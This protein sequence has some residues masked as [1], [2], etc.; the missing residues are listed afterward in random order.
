MA[1][2]LSVLLALDLPGGLVKDVTEYD[3]GPKCIDTKNVRWRPTGKAEKLGGWQSEV[4][5]SFI[6]TPRAAKNWRT[7]EGHDC[8]VVCTQCRVE[9]VYD[10][11][12][13]DITP[14][15]TT[16]NPL[17]NNPIATVN[18]ES[19]V[20]VTWAGHGAIE[21]TRVI[22]SGAV[23]VNG[24]TL[25]GEFTITEIVNANSFKVDSGTTASGTG[26]GGGAAVVGQLL[27]NCGNTQA[28]PGLGWGAGPWSDSTWGTPRS[29][30]TT[31]ISLESRLWSLDLWGEDL[32]INVRNG[33]VY[34]WDAS[35]GPG[36]RAAQIT[37]TPDR[38]RF[39][40]ISS[41]D[42][43]LVLFGSEPDGGG[44][45]DPMLSLWSDRGDYEV[46]T[47]TAT[48]DA[49]DKRL[50][51]GTKLVGV[52][53]TRDTFMVSTDGA[54]YSMVFQGPPFTF[55]F[56]LI[57][58]TAS[59]AMIS[60]N[61]GCDFFGTGYYMGKDGFYRYNGS[62]ARIPCP[63]E[64]FI[65]DDLNRDQIDCVTCGVN[66]KFE[67]IWWF[68]PKAG[69]TN[70]TRL[71]IFKPLT[72]HFSVFDMERTVFMDAFSYIG[73]PYALNSDGTLIYHERGNDDDNM[74]MEAYVTFG[75]IELKTAQ[76]PDG[77]Q[78]MLMRQFLPNITTTGEVEIEISTRKEPNDSPVVKGPFTVTQA[79][80]KFSVR[81]RGRQAEITFRSVDLG[82]AW[83]LGRNRVRVQP[84]GFR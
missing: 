40:R 69:D 29:L 82:N 19:E 16:L 72:G 62:V 32:I 11:V 35:A 44:D 64:R 55:A 41:P 54:I 46:Y 13:F 27:L 23:I 74:P 25:N 57:S 59:A 66:G 9:L 81:A 53:L 73:S 48:N 50:G 1:D 77:T 10:G 47:P 61:A 26:S 75:E 3:A 51:I 60:Q 65:F 39:I 84:D 6:G 45:Q 33:K 43:H 52:I 42:L 79:T 36:S 8:L 70:P 4:N 34:R 38:V 15:E 31:G 30:A 71:I 78:L 83:H 76:D 14:I 12:K 5:F 24:I 28:T 18:T 20:T 63:V 7:L 2:G 80:R 49:G 17:T 22:F 67:E 37:G 58:A 21:G 56:K 68:V